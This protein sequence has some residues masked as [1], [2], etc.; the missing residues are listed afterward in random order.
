MAASAISPV[1]VFV[2]PSF[3][4]YDSAVDK[5]ISIKLDKVAFCFE[6]IKLK[7]NYIFVFKFSN[8]VFLE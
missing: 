3:T 4:V 6:S 5:L 7:S 2:S 8:F 1:A